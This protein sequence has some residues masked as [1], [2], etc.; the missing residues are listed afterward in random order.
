MTDARKAALAA[1]RKAFGRK[2]HG[3]QHECAQEARKA[4]AAR[5]AYRLVVGLPPVTK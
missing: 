4:L 5:N 1:K 2:M 3:G